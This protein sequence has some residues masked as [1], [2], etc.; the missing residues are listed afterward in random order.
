MHH[1]FW[2]FVA[3]FIVYKLS[4]VFNLAGFSINT[5]KSTIYYCY[6]AGLPQPAILYDIFV[7][8]MPLLIRYFYDKASNKFFINKNN[9]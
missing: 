8:A 3:N 9:K 5:F 1:L 4:S 7:I 2:L 6:T